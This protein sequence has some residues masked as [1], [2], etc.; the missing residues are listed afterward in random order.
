MKRGIFFLASALAMALSTTAKAEPPQ[1]NRPTKVL[2]AT[3][4]VESGIRSFYYT[5]YTYKNVS[6]ESEF[7]FW[8]IGLREKYVAHWIGPHGRL[9]VLAESGRMGS[10][11]SKLWVRDLEAKESASIPLGPGMGIVPQSAHPKSPFVGWKFDLDASGLKI[12][13]GF[14]VQFNLVIDGIGE[15]HVNERQASRSGNQYIVT[16]NPAGGPE[17]ELEKLLA[18][19]V[20]PNPTQPIAEKKNWEVWESNSAL[21]SGVL[22]IYASNP[23]YDLGDVKF[24][25]HEVR[26]GAPSFIRDEDAK[27]QDAL[28]YVRNEQRDARSQTCDIQSNG[29]SNGTSRLPGERAFQI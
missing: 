20:A 15:F 26:I 13:D 4:T 9:W 1:Q 3:T 8:R 7:E 22:A 21:G 18:E 14:R 17:S 25:Q 11:Q 16:W 12:I 27:R 28:V 29:R 19:S 23:L 5:V 6:G 10:S 2:E 24:V